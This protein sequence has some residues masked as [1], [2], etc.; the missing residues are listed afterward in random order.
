MRMP[1]QLDRDIFRILPYRNDGTEILLDITSTRLQ[2]AAVS[3]PRHK[4]VAKELTEAINNSWKLETYC[5]FPLSHDST[6][7][8]PIRCHVVEVC[9]SDANPPA[10]MRW[11]PVP[12]LAADA[13]EDAGDFA[14]IQS[15][16]GAMDRYRQGELPGA[17]GRP[18]WLRPITAWVEIHA[19]AVGLSLNGEFRQLN[20][21][22]EF[23]LIRFET[24]G[25]ALWFKAVGEPNLHE[26]HITRKLASLFPNFLPRILSTH[27]DWNAW[28]AVETEGCPLDGDSTH[29]SWVAA[30]ENLAIL[31]IETLGRGFELVK[32]GCKDLRPCSL[33]PLVAPFLETMTELM[34]QQVKL[35]P[36][37]LSQE[38]LLSLGGEI[39]AS[40][41]EFEQCGIPN[42]LG[43]LDFNTRNILVSG[44]GCVFLDWA[45]AYVGPP[46]F[47]FQYLLER[48]RQCHGFDT[49]RQEFL[50]SS[51]TRPWAR[52]VL[53]KQIAAAF[54]PVPL[55]A[56]FSYAVGGTGW[57]NRGTIHPETAR[58]LRSLTRRMK[59][60]AAA[61]QERRALC[62]PY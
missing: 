27:A 62:V 54:R 51:Y 56:A 36:P 14:A 25:P 60:E 45:E 39:I 40:L 23:S 5:L 20:A 34:Q 18:G 61:L 42:A 2:L 22:A 43:H 48:W 53:S 16:C 31:Q 58:Y 26:Y 15:T 29:S 47:T 9:R 33:V 59:R 8:I 38:Q 24:D 28:L 50:I 32:A 13:F 19:R 49:D 21:S 12:S 11:F 52:F 57:Q 46:F 7:D 3:V 1:K 37:P 17:F 30:A 55:L 35:S 10:G 41:N 4:R 44:H 6:S